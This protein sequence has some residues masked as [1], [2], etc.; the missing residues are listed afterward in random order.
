MSGLTRALGEVIDDKRTEEVIS[1]CINTM[2]C[3][4]RSPSRKDNYCCFAS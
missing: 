1:I 2:L 3:M 4:I